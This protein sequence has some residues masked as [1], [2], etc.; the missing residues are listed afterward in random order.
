M[1]KRGHLSAVACAVLCL[2]LNLT[3]ADVANLETVEVNSVGDNISDSGIDEGFLNKN[4]QTGILAGKRS[5]DVPYQIN[6]I[7]KETMNNQGVTGF[8][9]AFKYFPSASIQMFGGSV[10]GRPQTRGFGG[11]VVGNVFWDGF[12]SIATTA[13]PMAMFESL[14]IQNGIAGSLYGAQNPTGIFSYVRKRPIDNEHTIWADYTSRENVGIGID[15]SMKFDKFGYRAVFYGSDGAKQVKDSNLQRRLASVVFE[16]YPTDTLTLEAAASYYEHNSHGF[17]GNFNLPIANGVARY[18][19]PTAGDDKRQGY[20]QTYGGMNLENT[21]LSAKFKYA[22]LEH[23]YF[24][25]GFAWQRID[26]DTH[27]IMNVIKDN[28]GNFDVMHQGGISNYRY[29]LPSGYLK[30][31]TDFETFGLK[32]DFSVQANGYRWSTFR[33]A[34]APTTLKAGEASMSAPRFFASPGARNGSELFKVTQTDMMNISALDEVTINENFSLMLSASNAW[35]KTKSRASNRRTNPLATQYDDSGLSYA[36]SLIYRPADNVSLYFTYADSLQKGDQGVNLDGSIVVLKPYRAKQYEIGAKARLG[37]TDLSAAL[38]KMQRPLAYLGDNG[39][40]EEQGEQVNYGFEFMAGGKLSQNLS[41][42][43]GI[44]LLDPKAK[45]PKLAAA[46]DKLIAGVSKVNS[47]LLFDYVVPNT[48]KLAFSAN[49]HYNGGFYVDDVNSQKTPGFF[50]TDIGVRYTSKTLLG[51]QA[52]LRFNVNNLFNKKYWAGMS[53]AS[54][55]GS[56]ANSGITN[57][58]SLGES[59]LFLLSAEVKF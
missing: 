10:A 17:A 48:Q 35:I 50:V 21:M 31:V 23:W 19:L 15:S 59:R 40:F 9:E 55:D 36:G 49:F 24:E 37:E 27:R 45:S 43:G 52:T 26:R 11:E 57:G 47:N 6:T 38:F 18:A 2:G 1:L 46:D 41:V 3:A 58:L 56:G 28:N 51:K 30:A 54:M 25:G 14:Q 5:L 34:N 22:P 32:H 4:I 53:P 33:F 20:G 16:F 44:T 42:L 13:I 39:L 8:E 29:E 7:T 12:Y